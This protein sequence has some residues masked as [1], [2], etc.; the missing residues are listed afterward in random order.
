MLALKAQGVAR[1]DLGT[2]DTRRAPGIAR[3]KLGAGARVE[4]LAG[5]W[6]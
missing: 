2:I 5:S 3:F 1:L 4:V 6:T